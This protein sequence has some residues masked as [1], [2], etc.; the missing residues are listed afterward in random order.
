MFLVN[1]VVPMTPFNLL[2]HGAC[3]ISNDGGRA[4]VIGMIVLLIA[5]GADGDDLLGSG[6]EM[7]HP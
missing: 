7:H 3:L 2:L 5:V 6:I 4:E 1:L